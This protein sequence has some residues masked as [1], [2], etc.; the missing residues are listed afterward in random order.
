MCCLIFTAACT[1]CYRVSIVF[2][3]TSCHG[4]L[5]AHAEHLPSPLS[6]A[7]QELFKLN[8]SDRQS[9]QSASLVS[10]STPPLSS[11]TPR[12]GKGDSRA[13]GDSTDVSSDAQ[14]LQTASGDV[15]IVAPPARGAPGRSTRANTQSTPKTVRKESRAHKGGALVQEGISGDV[16]LEADGEVVTVEGE[17][18]G[19]KRQEGNA[20]GGGGGGLDGGEF[21]ESG[22]G[23]EGVG[24][25]SGVAPEAQEVADCSNVLGKRGRGSGNLQEQGREA[26]E[27]QEEMIVEQDVGVG[28][29]EGGLLLSGQV[30]Q[31]THVEGCDAGQKEKEAMVRDLVDRGNR[32][33]FVSR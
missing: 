27:E 8:R 24:D 13:P 29:S 11:S 21:R 19:M 14:H 7:A 16:G 26:E 5:C 6:I 12:S 20:E 22:E 3:R 10:P 28:G 31:A 4:A 30:G 2:G 25:D 15:I 32:C 1:P 33:L 9:P 23:G 17:G 18:V